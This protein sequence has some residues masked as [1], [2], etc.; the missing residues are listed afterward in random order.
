MQDLSG[1]AQALQERL[2]R[3]YLASLPEKR[4]K[5]TACWKEVQ[6]GDW[7]PDQVD[8]MK[9]EIHRLAGSA[10]SYGLEE[11]GALASRLENSLKSESGIP[12]HRLVIGRQTAE[13]LD[14]LAAKAKERT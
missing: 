12:E 8:R 6:S 4:E 3:R 1:K 5:I 13:L 11:L 2:V 14:A 10:G 7:N 9:I